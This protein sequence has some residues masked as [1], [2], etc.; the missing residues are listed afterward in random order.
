MKKIA[1]LIVYILSSIQV[2]A[3]NPAAASF[4]I[5]QSHQ[6]WQMRAEF[7]W[8]LQ[9]V[10][11]TTFPYLSE[12]AQVAEED[13][14]DCVADYMRINLQIRADGEMVDIKSIRQIPGDHGHSYT[15]LLE[16]DGPAESCHV[17]I[18]NLCLL[19]LYPKQKNDVVLKSFMSTQEI[20][21]TNEIRQHLFK[22]C[23]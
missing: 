22:L 15:F 2:M 7:S 17:L 14:I 11:T 8:A 4:Y 20:V 21:M 9:K 23:G 5:F 3:H 19:E 18:T 16:L 10:L 1:I 13:Y 6:G 12:E